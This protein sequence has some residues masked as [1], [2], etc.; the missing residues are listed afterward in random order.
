[1]SSTSTRTAAS[2]H[3]VDIDEDGHVITTMMVASPHVV[4]NIVH[5]I[6]L[7]DGHHTHVINNNDGDGR[8]THVNNEEDSHVTHVDDRR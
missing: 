3:V 7:G 8:V 5:L 1:M 6:H 2:P 4:D